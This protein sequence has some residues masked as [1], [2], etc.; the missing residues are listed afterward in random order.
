MMA[1]L[2][3]LIRWFRYPRRPLPPPDHIGRLPTCYNGVEGCGMRKPHS[4]TDD[5]IRRLKQR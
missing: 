4:H 2:R 1:L 5:L 3:W